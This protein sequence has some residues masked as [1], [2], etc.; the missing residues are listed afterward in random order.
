MLLDGP[1]KRKALIKALCPP[2][3]VPEVR[4]RAVT[5]L[6]VQRMLLQAIWSWAFG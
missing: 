1:A 5:Y 6:Y 2:G 4:I 3:L